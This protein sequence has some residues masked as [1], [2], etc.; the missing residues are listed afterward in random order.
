MENYNII[1]YCIYLPI[2]FY[3]TI[4]VGR[5]CY[6]NG[7]VYLSRIINDH[8][9]TVKAINSLL[10][11]G[12][13]LLNLGYAAITLSFWQQ[14]HDIRGLIEILSGKLGTIIMFLGLMHF[15]NMLVT[16]IISKRINKNNQS[17][18]KPSLS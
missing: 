5:I 14:I 17:S 4:V 12:Y 18:L 1:A 6:Q 10:L 15:N 3:I 11:V 16:Y 8:P 13:Y 2:T 9:D 7:E